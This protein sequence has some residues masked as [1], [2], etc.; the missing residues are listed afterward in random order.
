[1]CQ[2]PA[3][4]LPPGSVTAIPVNMRYCPWAIPS[5]YSETV[6]CPCLGAPDTG[7]SGSTV[8][9]WTQWSAW[10]DCP[11]SCGGNATTLQTRTRACNTTTELDTRK[12]GAKPC[13]VCDASLSIVASGTSI[14]TVGITATASNVY[15]NLTAAQ[16]NFLVRV[17]VFLSA[18][19]VS[20]ATMPQQFTL[21]STLPYTTNSIVIMPL[22][23][24][25]TCDSRLYIALA[26]DI[27][28]FG[29]GTSTGWINSGTA[30]VDAPSTGSYMSC[31]NM[32][33]R[34]LARLN[35]ADTEPNQCCS[36]GATCSPFV[37]DLV[38]G[39]TTNVV[40]SAAVT[41]TPDGLVFIAKTP[42]RE[43]S[44][45]ALRALV[46]VPV[47]DDLSLYNKFPIQFKLP[48]Q[49][50]SIQTPVLSWSQLRVSPPACNSMLYVTVLVNF[51]DATTAVFSGSVNGALSIC[52]GSG[53]VRSTSLST[54]C[55]SPA[56]WWQ[57]HSSNAPLIAYRTPWPV[58]ED[59]V[60][61]CQPN[62]EHENRTLSQILDDPPT[63]LWEVLA[64]QWIAARLNVV[65]GAPDLSIST[66]LDE[67]GQLLSYC[68][69]IPLDSIDAAAA[70]AKSLED[71]NLGVTGPGLCVDQT[72]NQLPS[73]N[74]DS[75]PCRCL[76]S[77]TTTLV[78]LPAAQSK[79]FNFRP[80]PSQDL[81]F[82]YLTSPPPA[83]VYSNQS[84]SNLLLPTAAIHSSS[85]V[86]VTVRSQNLFSSSVK[87]GE[88]QSTRKRWIEEDT[89]DNVGSSRSAVISIGVLGATLLVLI[90]AAI[91][92]FKQRN[93]NDSSE[94][95]YSN[96]I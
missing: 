66:A 89:S 30:F 52:C 85:P 2:I 55:T 93:D 19:P 37:S 31:L 81:S 47:R 73:V 1:M 39:G 77:Q 29:V 5:N 34:Q 59:S 4:I 6:V 87:I 8:C 68:H 26:V 32:C 92:Y 62:T 28:V 64:Q 24:N 14:G 13:D 33:E 78:S 20:P 65:A 23:T 83:I 40:G 35:D 88:Q 74:L 49:V 80:S 7:G 12:C 84:E 44:Y 17:R 21:D 53:N 27:Y 94:K 54:A 76:S 95:L 42:G 10:S 41:N 43:I 11:V 3:G 91:M 61:L 45:V 70:L 48:T 90:V 58:P 63:D 50:S 51:S 25:T 60:W 22:P 69:N 72:G 18:N 79:V 86:R 71:F 67:A 38:N 46:T 96:F 57:T 16:Q 82:S 56:S 36:C 75:C 15:L 9:T